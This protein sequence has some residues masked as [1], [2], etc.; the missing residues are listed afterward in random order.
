MSTSGRTALRVVAVVV[1]VLLVA[2]FVVTGVP[3]IIGAEESFVVLSGSMNAEPDPVIRAG[4]VVVVDAVDPANIEEGDVITFTTGE[5]RPITHR[6]VDVTEGDDGTVFRTKGDANEDADP[7]PV[8]PDQVVGEVFLV[9]PLIGYVVDFANTL[10]GFVLLV[11]L[12]IGL[13]VISEA[14]DLAAAAGAS[15]DDVPGAAERPRETDRTGTAGETGASET[16]G[17]ESDDSDEGAPTVTLQRA[18][19]RWMVAGLLPAAAVAGYAAFRLQ[20][21]V[22]TTVFYA[23]VGLALLS[24]FLYWRTA[25]KSSEKPDRSVPAGDTA[26]RGFPANGE[27]N[28]PASDSIAPPADGGA[29]RRDPVVVG[30]FDDDLESDSRIVVTVDSREELVRMAVWKGRWVV[31]DTEAGIHALVDEDVLFRYEGDRGADE[32]GTPEGTAEDAARDGS[33]SESGEAIGWSHLRDG[34]ED[35]EA[36]TR[37]GPN[38]AESAEREF[39]SVITR[40]EEGSEGST[41]D[42]IRTSEQVDADGQTAEGA[43]SGDDPGEEQPVETDSGSATQRPPV[44]VTVDRLVGASVRALG[45]VGYLVVE[46]PMML[47]RFVRSKV[48]RTEPEAEL[49]EERVT[50]R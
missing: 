50:E 22:A 41:D 45:F 33:V 3:A 39:T 16:D 42:R 32:G 43:S 10:Q 35:G 24:G 31:H 14:W 25:G 38:G 4:D 8:E 2:P 5:T 30:Q 6:V 48:W 15:D 49:G 44:V 36:E 46:P 9:L 21:A 19:L 18:Q 40:V 26:L 27:P 29:E 13:L 23:S 7:Q 12:P 11:L 28:R 17:R 47:Y 37:D 20:S 1:L 34:S